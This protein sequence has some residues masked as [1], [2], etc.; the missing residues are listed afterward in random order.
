MEEVSW[1][2]LI[3]ESHE[4]GDKVDFYIYLNK[5]G[6]LQDIEADPVS[7]KLKNLELE[8]LDKN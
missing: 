3:V 7:S 8:N 6:M 4:A 2:D 1:S 5:K